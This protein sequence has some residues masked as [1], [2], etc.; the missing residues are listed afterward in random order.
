MYIMLSLGEMYRVPERWLVAVII[1]IMLDIN[2]LTYVGMVMTETVFWISLLTALYFWARYMH[3]GRSSLRDVFGFAVMMNWAVLVRPVILY[4]NIL[5][6]FGLLLCAVLKRFNWKHL[7]AYTAITACVIGGWFARNYA[8]SGEIV[9]STVEDYNKLIWSGGYV[10]NYINGNKLDAIEKSQ[11]SMV[12]LVWN[13]V[14]EDTFYNDMNEAQRMKVYAQAGS[15]YLKEHRKEYIIVNIKGLFT[16]Y[17]GAYK[18]FWNE[19][20]GTNTVAFNMCVWL[21]RLLLLAEY[22]SLAYSLIKNWKKLAFID[23]SIIVVILYL[24]LASMPCGSSRFRVPITI[25]ICTEIIIA[26]KHTDDENE[27]KLLDRLLGQKIV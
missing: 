14:D 18:Q 23:T 8:L 25:L 19:L 4:F 1:A 2:I 26:N 7:L 24:T 27:T 6:I 17:F 11:E 13:Y 16:T 22:V 3:S 9:F 5:L 21:Y 20:W 12:S 10:Y 15:D